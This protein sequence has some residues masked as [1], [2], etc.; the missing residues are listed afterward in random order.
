M[1]RNP[2]PLDLAA[3]WHGW[4][5]KQLR[6][7]RALSMQALCDDISERTGE[8]ITLTR[9]AICR[10]EGGQRRVALRYRRVLAEA[11]G[12]DHL[13]LFEDPPAGWRPVAKK[14]NREAA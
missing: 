9:G 14:P 13:L 8:R 6:E 1:E 5:I 7:R 4:R 10:W 11:L 2:R 12:T 3:C